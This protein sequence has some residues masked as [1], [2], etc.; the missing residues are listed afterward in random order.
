MIIN[1]DQPADGLEEGV[2]LGSMTGA[3][4]KARPPAKFSKAVSGIRSRID[5]GEFSSGFAHETV[6][7]G[8]RTKCTQVIGKS[9]TSVVHSWVRFLYGG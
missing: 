1:V 9:R 7:S 3:Q 4:L 2:I 5:I 8:I 6:K